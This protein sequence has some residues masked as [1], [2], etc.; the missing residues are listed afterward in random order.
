MCHKKKQKENRSL[1][2]AKNESEIRSDT[3]FSSVK[4]AENR[5]FAWNETWEK[6][7]IAMQS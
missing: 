2:R 3:S 4:T 5:N 1:T 6:A 7:K